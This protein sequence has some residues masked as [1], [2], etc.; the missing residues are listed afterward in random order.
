MDSKTVFLSILGGIGQAAGAMFLK[1]AEHRDLLDYHPV[2]HQL[3]FWSKAYQLAWP[4]QC[5]DVNT[6]PF[7][8]FLLRLDS[9]KHETYVI[10]Q[11]IC[12]CMCVPFPTQSF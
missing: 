2:D 3:R 5:I 6:S 7:S 8:L 4:M 10:M 12:I 11:C 1:R 9:F